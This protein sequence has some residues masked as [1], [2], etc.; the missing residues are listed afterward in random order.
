GVIFKKKGIEPGVL[1]LQHRV[2]TTGSHRPPSRKL[3]E[4]A[5][6]LSGCRR[7]LQHD[8]LPPSASCCLQLCQ[9][10]R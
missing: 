7:L 5:F 9:H 6:P 8:S 10:Q 4:T 3:R 2:T 1:L